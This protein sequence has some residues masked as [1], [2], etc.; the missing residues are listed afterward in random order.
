MKH[1]RVF[2]GFESGLWTRTVLPV[3]KTKLGQP[4]LSEVSRESADGG[5][6]PVLGLPCLGT[7]FL[8]LPLEMRSH[9][10]SKFMVGMRSLLEHFV[11]LCAW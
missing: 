1:G 10:K 9:A 8:F 11:L 7:D 3:K 6:L 2:N 5:I 4:V